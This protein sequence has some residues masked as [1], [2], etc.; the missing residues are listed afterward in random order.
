MSV[1]IVNTASVAV[2]TATQTSQ[3]LLESEQSFSVDEY[4][5]VRIDLASAGT[6]SF[7]GGEQS[8]VIASDLSTGNT[9]TIVFGGNTYEL[10]SILILPGGVGTVVITNGLTTTVS[11]EIFIIDN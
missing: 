6:H 7:T 2:T 9:I 1:T 10:G 5:S 4:N 11:L 8:T 3:I